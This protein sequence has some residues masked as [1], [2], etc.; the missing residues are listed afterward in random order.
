[1]H[2]REGEERRG[3][4]SCNWH[5]RTVPTRVGVA[6]APDADGSSSSSASSSPNF[7]HKDGRKISVG[8]CALFKPPQDSPPF[9]GIIRSLT[10][11]KDNELKLGVNWL[12]RPAEVKLS[13]GILLEAAPNEIF[14]SFHRDETLAASLLHPCKVAFL[15]KGVELPSGI[16]SFVCRRVYDI[17]NSCLWWLTDQDYINE[18]QEEVDQLLYKTRIE[19]HA[20]V[21]PNGRSPKQMNGPTSASQLKSGSDC[22]QNSA[23]SFASQSKGKKRERGDQGSEPIKRERSIKMED[24]DSGY[25]RS[26]SFL[27]NEIAKIT[28]KGGLVNLEGVEKLVQLMLPDRSEKK[29]D[30]AG[31]SMLTGVIAGTD[32]VDKRDC[33]SQFVQLKGL[34]VLDEWLQEVHKG[35]V[36]DGCSLKDNDKSVDEFILVLLRALDKLP[37][38]LHALQM[39]NIGK[40][41]NNLRSHKNSEIQKKARS[42]VDTWKKGVEAEMNINEVGHGGNRNV[43][44]SS[45]AA[46]RSSVSLPA[47]RSPSVK[48]IQGESAS[49][50]AV[51]PGS[52]KSAPSHASIGGNLKDGQARSAVVSSVSDLPMT[53]SRDEKSSS[54]SQSHNNSQSCSSDHAKTGGPPGKEDARSSTAGSGRV[55]SGPSRHKKLVNCLP[56]SSASGR[57][58]G[59]SR[60]SLHRN[61]APEK[62]SQSGLTS[63]RA[64]DVPFEVNS[65]KLIVKIP[66]RGRSPAQNA[67]GG[68]FDDPSVMISRASS[69]MRPE[70]PDQLDPALK[71]KTDACQANV[72]SDVNAES[73]QNND[74]KDLVT[75]CDEGDGSPGTAPQDDCLKT[76]ENTKKAL[77]TSKTAMSSSGSEFKLGRLPEASPSSMKALV[78]SCVKVFEPSASDSVEDDVGMNLLASVA[79]G[80]MLMS[81]MVSPVDSPQR[82]PSAVGQSCAGNDSKMN[83]SPRNHCQSSGAANDCVQKDMVNDGALLT[84]KADN[85]VSPLPSEDV[86]SEEQKRNPNSSSTEM[87]QAAEPCPESNKNVNDLPLV[88]SAARS[89]AVKLYMTV[90][91][92]NDDESNTAI[93]RENQDAVPDSKTKAIVSLSSGNKKPDAVSSV[94]VAS[95]A[96]ELGSFSSQKDGRQTN[97]DSKDGMQVDERPTD[98]VVSEDMKPKEQVTKNVDAVKAERT[99]GTDVGNRDTHMELRSVSQEVSVATSGAGFANYKGGGMEENK[100][101]RADC[102]RNLSSSKGLSDLPVQVK[103]MSAKSRLSKLTGSGA[104]EIKE[105]A[106]SEVSSLAVTEG[107]ADKDAKVRFD[108]N[109]G[110]NTDDVKY[111]EPA[112]LAAHASAAVVPLA[113]RLPFATSSVSTSLSAP[114]PVAAAAKGPFVPPD[115]LLRTKVELGWKGSAATSAF[116]PAEPRKLL[117]MPL[118]ATNPPPNPDTAS[119]KPSRPPLDI[120]LN[121]PDEGIVEDAVSRNSI[122]ESTSLPSFKSNREIGRD[123]MSSS[124]PTRG[125]GGL[126]LD[127]NQIDEATDSWS[128]STSSKCRLDV[129]FSLA[130]SSAGSLPNGTDTGAHRDFDLN[131]GPAVDDLS[132]EPSI[133]NQHTRSSVPSQQPVSGLK[134]NNLEV[135]NFSSWFHPGSTYSAV[136]IPSMLSRGEQSLP[137]VATGGQPRMLGPSTGGIP[138]NTEIYRTPVLSSSPAVAFPPP[139][140]QYP[141]FSPYAASFPLQSAT[142]SN[143]STTYV[144]PSSG[145]R[146]CFPPVHSQLLGLPGA[147]STN[148][149]RPFI[150]SLPDGGNS[151]ENNKKWTRQ[152]L[153]LNTGPGG[154]D[155][156]GRDETSSLAPRQLSVVSSQALAEDQARMYQ[157]SSGVLKRKE[158]DGGWDNYKQSSW[159]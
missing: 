147:V 14:Y 54:S 116:R 16:C 123:E 45:E 122:L 18:H 114:I 58:M 41:V 128:Y 33:L 146:L 59:S 99:D 135:G 50:S 57:E 118:L 159:Q 82:N 75:A 37:V 145:G 148:I 153:D 113:N 36:G 85:K 87:L 51:S 131:D 69:P 102:E 1:M 93:D 103:D 158:P 92:G 95:V 65:H 10:S 26:E 39:C 30:L 46:T 9:I 133:P 137:V 91:S 13:R 151:Y 130:K 19:M 144:D 60:T 42:L 66:N 48:L 22:V 72:S 7:F 141:V 2:G 44:G 127:L 121:V 90:D 17:S 5:M 3:R 110:L 63:E 155:L 115:D 132:A 32:K 49:K 83:S 79:A 109:E 76:G 134:M 101:S 117:E 52:L 105:F 88:T 150:V 89:P 97:E 11:S 23:S 12:Y 156:E 81:E 71:E 53:T 31:R 61:V 119:A 96:A 15:P 124:A 138:F 67:S 98:T 29:V 84:R 25:S 136:T 100:E 34:S 27:R 80:E 62:V 120:D 94:E 68:S 126:G 104:D 43:G 112:N 86:L 38:N 55:S 64:V 142:F 108:L 6:V 73:W 40:S 129:N 77:E 47:S 139:P 24:G 21:Q 111:G 107:G 20:T 152:V 28:D 125:S 56:G 8:D 78:E 4:R 143:S 106:S 157:V 154:P 74:L 140:F 35:K 70:R 149:S